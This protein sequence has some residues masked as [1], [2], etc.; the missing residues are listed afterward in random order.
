MQSFILFLLEYLCFYFAYTYLGP[1][2]RSNFERRS[3]ATQSGAA[4]E[5]HFNHLLHG[6][7]TDVKQNISNLV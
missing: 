2:I 3:T 5:K 1:S 7:G 6:Q 4:F